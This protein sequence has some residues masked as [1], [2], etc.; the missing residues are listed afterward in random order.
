[1][2]KYDCKIVFQGMTYLVTMGENLPRKT[3]TMIPLTET[4]LLSMI[5]DGGFQAVL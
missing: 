2:F 1:M 5:P 3:K 4:V